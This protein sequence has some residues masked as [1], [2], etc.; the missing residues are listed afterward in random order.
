[1]CV[2]ANSTA[3]R[4]AVVYVFM[5]FRK[6]AELRGG[7]WIAKFAFAQGPASLQHDEC[8]PRCVHKHATLRGAFVSIS[9][10]R[11]FRQ[12]QGWHAVVDP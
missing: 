5:V 7:D 4:L 8:A 12:P 1:M 2:V 9:Q 10:A 6:E 11:L 3:R